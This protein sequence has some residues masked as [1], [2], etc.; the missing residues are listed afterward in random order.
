M[1]SFDKQ[2]IHCFLQRIIIIYM[3]YNFYYKNSLTS[4][5]NNLLQYSDISVR[6]FIQI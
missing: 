4:K 3:Y 2:W 5:K 6:F 1:Y